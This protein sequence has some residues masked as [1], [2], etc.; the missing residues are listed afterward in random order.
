M[1]LIESTRRILLGDPMP[2]PEDIPAASLPEGV[3]LRRGRLIPRI[4]GLLARMG[5]PAAAVTLGRTI[6]VD[7]DVRLTSTLLAHELAHVRQWEQDALFPVRYTL[8]SLR[9][10]Y[11][12]NPYEVE[13]RDASA[14]FAANPS[15]E[16]NT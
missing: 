6:V 15:S 16:V 13:A 2:L 9:H 5:G 14:S 1:S 7:P 3:V 8:A 4:G 11:R 10:G 12:Q